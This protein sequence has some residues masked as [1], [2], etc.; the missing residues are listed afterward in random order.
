MAAIHLAG[1]R[2]EPCGAER[3]TQWFS[4]TI[5]TELRRL[6]EMNYIS[7]EIRYVSGIQISNQELTEAEGKREKA[8]RPV[9]IRYLNHIDLGT[10]TTPS[11]SL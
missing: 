9:I 10:K 2:G 6:S 8:Y 11:N 7:V 1:V 3:R 4:A 5:S